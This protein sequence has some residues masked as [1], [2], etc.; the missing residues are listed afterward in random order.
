MIA[1][2]ILVVALALPPMCALAQPTWML[3]EMRAYQAVVDP[4]A[5]HRQSDTVALLQGLIGE[6][7]AGSAEARSL[8]Y[9]L[10]ALY[11]RQLNFAEAEVLIAP[12]RAGRGGGPTLVYR[13]T[14]VRENMIPLVFKNDLAGALALGSAA[15]P[16]YVEELNVAK[17]AEEILESAYVDTV[18]GSAARESIG[19]RRAA[20][21]ARAVT[22]N[23]EL[24][25]LY[26]ALAETHHALN[27]LPEA[28]KQYRS[29]LALFAKDKVGDPAAL[30][31][32]R[33]GLAI[34]LRTS[35]DAGGALPLQQA[36]LADMKKSYP[37]NHPE[38]LES[39][40]EL[41]QLRLA[42]RKGAAKSGKRAG[43][44]K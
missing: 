14:K 28:E 18:P 17:L 24:A 10:A 16:R 21:S 2:L 3:T 4:N 20:V 33:T 5:M 29:A 42:L 23:L 36:A 15:V 9:R 6:A 27:Q 8:K 31:H 13:P 43:V 37:D 44:A 19:G 26:S 39:E 12:L 30:I 1:R 25:R 7:E 35:G 41:T 38:R 34:L 11:Y 22:A 32:T 40:R